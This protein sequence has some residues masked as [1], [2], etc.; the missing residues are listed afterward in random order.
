MKT[1]AELLARRKVPR[2]LG[3]DDGPSERVAGA[4]VPVAGVVCAGDR[5]EG[6]L[7]AHATRDG[8]DA[9]EVIAE[10]IVGSKFWSQ[11]HVVLIDGIAIGGWNVIDLPTL[12]ERVERPCVA[13]MRKR[14]DMEAVERSLQNLPDPERRWGLIQ[15]AG[16]IH[17]APQAHFQVCGASAEEVVALLPA[18][19]S[20]GHVPEALRLA[21]LINSAI[22]FGQSTRRA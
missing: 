13:V 17:E 19:T 8:D 20:R 11:L 1:I 9:T 21:H 6:M 14:P 12:H 4:R 7:W 10:M 16:Q 2:V 5:M 18:L 3:V 22:A 15:R